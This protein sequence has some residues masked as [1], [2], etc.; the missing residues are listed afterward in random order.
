MYSLIKRIS[1]IL[2]FISC[3]VMPVHAEDANFKTDYNVEYVLN[4][5][6]TALDSRVKFDIKLTNLKTEYYVNKIALAFP[7][8][9]VISNVVARD[10]KGEV[11]PKVTT[12]DSR[13]KIEL[14]FNNPDIG[15][16]TVNSFHLEFDQANLF[17]INGNIWEVFLPTIEDKTRTSYNI[18]VHLPPNSNKKL[19]IAK[20]KP[21]S[22][23]GNDITWANPT[24]RTIYAV[25]GND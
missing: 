15:R 2:L 21:D 24:A 16:N 23:H 17:K 6:Q 14:H 18:V 12:D 5:N 19:S 20:P 25:F 3:F 7:K 9:F 11:V 10:N 22:I 4:E 1:F 8:S 13:V